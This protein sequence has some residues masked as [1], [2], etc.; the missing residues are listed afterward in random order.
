MK[1]RTSIKPFIGGPYSACFPPLPAQS[2]GYV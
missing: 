2:L 1:V